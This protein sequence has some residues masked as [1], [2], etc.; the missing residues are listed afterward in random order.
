MVG[1][2]GLGPLQT[3]PQTTEPKHRVFSTR[4]ASLKILTNLWGKTTNKQGVFHKVE[5]R[6]LSQTNE[7]RIISA[8]SRNSHKKVTVTTR[9]KLSVRLIIRTQPISSTIKYSNRLPFQ[10]LRCSLHIKTCHLGALSNSSWTINIKTLT[11]V[12]KVPN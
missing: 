7:C 3:K 6:K 2:A 5:V 12:K 11:E 4:L 8:N 9:R 1:S 10:F